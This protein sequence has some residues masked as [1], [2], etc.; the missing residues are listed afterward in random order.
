MMRIW[1]NHQFSLSLD[2]SLISTME[3][4]TRWMITNNLTNQTVVPDFLNN[5]YFEGLD[6][7]KPESVNI[8][9]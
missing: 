5:I 1:A 4:E 9:H 2:Q 8:I 7:V 6:S 3:A